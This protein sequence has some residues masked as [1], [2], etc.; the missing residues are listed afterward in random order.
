[1][2]KQEKI[3]LMKKSIEKERKFEIYFKRQGKKCQRMI[4]NNN[5]QNY[6]LH[7]FNILNGKINKSKCS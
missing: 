7:S 2:I 6:Y 1:M 5:I 3:N 4:S